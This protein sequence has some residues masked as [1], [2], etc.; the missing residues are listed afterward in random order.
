M[1]WLPWHEIIDMA[2]QANMSPGDILEHDSEYPAGRLSGRTKLFEIK[3]G[4]TKRAAAR[5][6]DHEKKTLQEMEAELYRVQQELAE[7]ERKKYDVR[8]KWTQTTP[9]LENKTGAKG[10][11]KE[12]HGAKGK[13]AATKR[14]QGKSAYAD[15]IQ[16]QRCPAWLCQ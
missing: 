16:S 10:R 12:G 1:P 2:R 7:H 15:T 8:H 14:Q 9:D 11:S 5:D 3:A 4:W 13:G 6:R